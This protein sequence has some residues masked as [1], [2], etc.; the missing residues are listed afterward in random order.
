MK[1][2]T[3]KKTETENKTKKVKAV[4]EIKEEPIAPVVEAE[5]SAIE[6]P[7]AKR[8]RKI[9]QRDAVRYNVD[10]KVGLN[11]EQVLERIEN[12]LTNHVKT[13]NS[14]SIP[15]IIIVLCAQLFQSCP[16]L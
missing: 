1:K 9:L 12:G 7:K 16:T 15:A 10:Y 11:N 4:K 6:L 2:Q 14:K 8:K 13:R 5:A 3:S